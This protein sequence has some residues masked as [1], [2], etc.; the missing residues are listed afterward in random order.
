MEHEEEIWRTLHRHLR[1]IL[2][3]DPQTYRAT[4]ADDLSLYEWFITP[5]RL[6]GMDFHMFMIERGAILEGARDY[7]YELLQPR[8][9]VYGDT[10]IASYTFFLTGVWDGPEGMGQP[11][12]VGHRSHNESRVLVRQEGE[13]KVVHVHKSP[14]WVAPRSPIGP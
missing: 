9:Q 2:E 6:D 4:T 12:S 14:D 10:A 1:S 13:W 7:H 3:R 8:L 5:H 11:T